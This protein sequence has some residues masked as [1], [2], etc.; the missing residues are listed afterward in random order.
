MP[1]G[2]TKGQQSDCCTVCVIT[3]TAFDFFEWEQGEQAEASG[4]AKESS[5][6]TTEEE[7]LFGSTKGQQSDCILCVISSCDVIIATLNTFSDIHSNAFHPA[8]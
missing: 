8:T 4:G 5:W 2:S 3:V 6:C 1:F 7:M